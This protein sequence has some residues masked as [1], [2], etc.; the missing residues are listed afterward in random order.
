MTQLAF[1]LD[2][3]QGIDGN[4]SKRKSRIKTLKKRIHRAEQRPNEGVSIYEIT[5]P[6]CGA[7]GLPTRTNG[8][9]INRCRPPTGGYL[10]PHYFH[11]ERR[12]LCA[13]LMQEIQDA[14]DAARKELET[15]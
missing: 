11:K 5:C 12:E 15:L 10:P 7:R 2:T 4:D 6:T 8:P 9:Q 1:N 13:R 14:A 3:G